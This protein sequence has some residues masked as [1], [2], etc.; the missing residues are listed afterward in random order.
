MIIKNLDELD[1][2]AT[3]LAQ[4]LTPNS[5]HSTVLA[6]SGDLGAG[7]TTF[8]QHLA[9]AL[10]VTDI[11]TSPTYVL[12]KRYPLKG[13]AFNNFIHV[14]AYRLE[15]GTELAKLDFQELLDDP[16]NVITIEWPEQVAD[17]IPDYAQKMNFTF[18]DENTREIIYG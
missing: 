3:S 15:G 10:G 11:V 7:K 8:V 14:D 18:V 9:K 2:F 13:Q 4:K 12:Q 17:I 6:L 1:A 5:N 16:Q